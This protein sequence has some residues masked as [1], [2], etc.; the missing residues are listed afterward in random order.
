MHPDTI[1]PFSLDLCE[2]HANCSFHNAFIGMSK[3]WLYHRVMQ[4]DGTTYISCRYF[5]HCWYYAYID[6]FD[7]YAGLF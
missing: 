1:D 2:A 6:V 5:S 4:F 3:F 7:I